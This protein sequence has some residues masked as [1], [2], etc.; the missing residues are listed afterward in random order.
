MASRYFGSG[1]TE[2][3]RKRDGG[4]GRSVLSGGEP[5]M[6]LLVGNARYAEGALGNPV[7]DVRLIG[8]TLRQLGFKVTKQVLRV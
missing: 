1:E 6:A 3:P 5:P 2:Q 8:R 4:T 7:N